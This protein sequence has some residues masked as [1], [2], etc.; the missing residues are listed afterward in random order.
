MT[1]ANDREPYLEFVTTNT[2]LRMS[3]S[4]TDPRFPDTMYQETLTTDALYLPKAGKY[5]CTEYVEWQLHFK[6]SV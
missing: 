6:G 4:S 2:P 5:C 3:K 1:V